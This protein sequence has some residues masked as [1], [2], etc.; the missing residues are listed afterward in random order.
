MSENG[1]ISLYWACIVA[2]CVASWVFWYMG[3]AIMR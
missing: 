1:V 2:L 3:G